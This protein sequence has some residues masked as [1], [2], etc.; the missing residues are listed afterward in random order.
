MSEFNAS[1]LFYTTLVAHVLMVLYA[2][3]RIL[4]SAPVKASRKVAFVAAPPGRS[5]TPETAA[6]SS[7]IVDDLPEEAAKGGP[8]KPEL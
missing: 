1:G 4:V 8:D 2:I 5:S 7:G 6:F 3:R